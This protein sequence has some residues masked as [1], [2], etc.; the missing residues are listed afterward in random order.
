MSFPPV[1][2]HLP[3]EAATERFAATVALFTCA[4]DVFCLNGPLGSGK[5]TFARAL[6]R[7]MGCQASHIPSPT[8]T[9]MQPYTDTRLPVAHVDAYRL[10]TP[11]E[12][13]A[14]DLNPYFIHGVTLIEWAEKVADLLP[15]PK[16]PAIHIG[17]TETPGR[18]DMHLAE[19]PE[20]GRTIT[21]TASGSWTKRLG[22]IISEN[23]GK[24]GRTMTHEGRFAFLTETAG[25]KEDQIAVSSASH[26]WSFRTYWRVSR[27][28][29]ADTILMDA[30]PPMENVQPFVKMARW[31]RET[32][33]HS[34]EIHATDETQGYLLLEDFGTTPFSKGFENGADVQMW[35]EGAVDLLA[36]LARHDPAPTW[37]YDKNALWC[38]VARFT[39]WCLPALTGEATDPATRRWFHDLWQPLFEK[40]L[41]VPAT[42]VHWDF[43]V[44]NMMMLGTTPG[45]TP[46]KPFE[47]I[48]LIDFQDARIGPATYDIASLVVSDR[49]P[50]PENLQHQLVQR[51]LA[52]LNEI[53]G[54]AVSEKAFWESFH[55][56]CLQRAMKNLGGL[57]RVSKRRDAPELMENLYKFWAI[58]DAML[59]YPECRPV[60]EFLHE[61]LPARYPQ[62]KVA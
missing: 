18:L 43:H 19:T 45:K 32:G 11:D 7:A 36:H 3:D 6:I 25:L 15:Q 12:L 49:Y 17:E 38:E 23:S 50:L 26:D 35:L 20:G 53:P 13:A 47:N 22:C 57:T 54:K 37:T 62:R 46:E 44:D 21:L 29:A 27:E 55:L 4:G 2:V 60:A 14:L 61:V 40:I 41:A 10:E 42:T 5:S 52:A 30:P 59:V 8:F 56:V 31:L 33:I 24:T 48:G 58:V 34:P 51:Y 16:T 1:K 9:L 39:D 28:G